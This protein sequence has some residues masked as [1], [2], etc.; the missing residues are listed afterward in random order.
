MIYQLN[1]SVTIPLPIVYVPS[2]S[3]TLPIDLLLANNSRHILSS[4]LIVIY[5]KSPLTSLLGFLGF[6]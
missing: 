4:N 3:A 6:Y 5:A 2:L 1:N